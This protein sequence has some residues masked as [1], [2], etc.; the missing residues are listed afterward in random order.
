[1]NEELE[2]ELK[3][4]MTKMV[5]AG[6]SKE[7]IAMFVKMFYEKHGISNQTEP[8]PQGGDSTETDSTET[9]YPTD[10]EGNV[11][12]IGGGMRRGDYFGQDEEVDEIVQDS[13]YWA[14]LQ[15][16]RGF[17]RDDVYDM[18]EEMMVDDPILS[19]RGNQDYDK[20][21]EGE[22]DLGL[23]QAIMKLQSEADDRKIITES[24][25]NAD[26]TVDYSDPAANMPTFSR[27]EGIYSNAENLKNLNKKFAR[28]GFKFDYGL[29]G[30]SDDLT[31]TD[32]EGNSKS[33]TLDE[34]PESTAAAV[35]EWMR[36]RAVDNYAE[37]AEHFDEI[38]LSTDD[39]K[40]IAE[41][42]GDEYDESL[43]NLQLQEEYAAWKVMRPNAKLDNIP[44]DNFYYD[45]GE[46]A[47]GATSVPE[48]KQ[49][50]PEFF[51]AK[52]VVAERAFREGLEGLSA[53]EKR[54][55][56]LT[57]EDREKISDIARG[58]DK[59]DPE[60][61]RIAIEAL[62]K[63]KEKGIVSERLGD[64]AGFLGYG[65]DKQEDGSSCR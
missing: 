22:E 38:G 40:K 4:Y 2:R 9:D 45:W 18:R 36:G 32:S 29:I 1:M 28:Y 47:F 26:T 30:L 8:Q 59:N 11:H 65:I 63:K 25:M 23:R 24:N 64:D 14:R 44:V 41:D 49:V 62:S 42:S 37:F 15:K 10:S 35:D 51:E 60:V 5:L 57:K 27:N 55:Y 12:R 20:E 61:R 58:I 43:T 39:R 34:N 46:S 31:V 19:F 33:W 17:T 56:K 13:D 21:W 50:L 3:T 54:K 52:L 16:A 53:E 48:H 7:D 6:S